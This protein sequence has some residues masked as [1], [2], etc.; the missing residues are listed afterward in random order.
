MILSILVIPSITLFV[1]ITH[2]LTHMGIIELVPL[3][4]QFD[5]GVVVSPIRVPSVNDDSLQG[6]P[7][8]VV[9][10]V[11]EGFEL[12]LVGEGQVVVKLDIH[13]GLKIKCHSLEVHDQGLWELGEIG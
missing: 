3:R 9:L 6:V 1:E 8:I 13:Q 12:D 4:V 2:E 11:H 10:V 7:E 5:Q